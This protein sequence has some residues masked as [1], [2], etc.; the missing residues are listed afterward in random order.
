MYI[1]GFVFVVVIVV[2]V[3]FASLWSSF[4]HSFSVFWCCKCI[5]ELSLFRWEFVVVFL[6]V[7]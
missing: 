5:A 4:L 6:F 7:A 2:L 1:G 3:V